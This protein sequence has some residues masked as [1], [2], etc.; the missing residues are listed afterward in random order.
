MEQAAEQNSLRGIL[1]GIERIIEFAQD[2]KE[3]R[4]QAK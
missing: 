1:S 4:E 3:W 2:L